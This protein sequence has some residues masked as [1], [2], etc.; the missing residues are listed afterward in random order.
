MFS[1]A[2]CR[3]TPGAKTGTN[4]GSAWASGASR[5]CLK[6][7]L[8]HGRHGPREQYSPASLSIAKQEAQVL[9][10]GVIPLPDVRDKTSPNQSMMAERG[11]FCMCKKSKIGE[12]LPLL[13]CYT[14]PWTEDQLKAKA[15]WHENVIQAKV[16]ELQVARRYMNTVT[17][18]D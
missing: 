3:R 12:V 7:S 17:S 9:A 15:P 2:H 14:V 16:I 10:H 18:K 5:R 11:M 6:Y 1:S 8:R 4:A 13:L